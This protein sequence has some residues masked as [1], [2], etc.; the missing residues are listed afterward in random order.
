MDKRKNDNDPLS[1]SK[2]KQQNQQLLNA[3]E[4]RNVQLHSL[5]RSLPDQYYLFTSEGVC[6][7]FLANDLSE[8]I[9]NPERMGANVVDLF[10]DPSIG[11]LVE[12]YIK[13]AASTGLLM[14]CKIRL[15]DLLKQNRYYE[16][17]FSATSDK[18]V[19]MIVRDVTNEELFK[20]KLKVKV[21]EL[22]KTNEKLNKYIQSNEELEQ[23]AYI[24]S[25]DLKE[26]IRNISFYAQYL[27]K[28][29]EIHS[30]K[31]KKY[32]D[33]IINRT[34]LM[35][36]LI[37]DLLLYSSVDNQD[38]NIEKI[39]LE[40]L[41]EDAKSRLNILIEQNNAFIRIDKNIT[42]NVDRFMFNQL[43]YNLI[44]N[45]I[46]YR[47]EAPPHIVI[48][49]HTTKNG[50]LLKVID[51]G[52]G[53]DKKYVEYVFGLFK[54]ISRNNIDG[55]GLGLSIARKIIERHFGEISIE[56]DIG[57]GSTINIKLPKK[58]NNNLS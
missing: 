9:I 51:N 52:I 16:C 4:Y 34:F 42:L 54:K 55:V 53:I 22:K 5:F 19:M 18:E 3:L 29:N 1:P 10:D 13:N 27:K 32:L 24:A 25:H 33:E 39:N 20:D 7:E 38:L 44:Q 43:F 14:T 26:P 8:L 47:G 17:R 46:K 40:T 37:D 2:L 31:G 30:D 48:E 15:I 12:E 36:K 41:I 45:A 35:K 58:I 6:K 50:I 49:G 56:S 23:F 21:D 11:E 57:K 28:D